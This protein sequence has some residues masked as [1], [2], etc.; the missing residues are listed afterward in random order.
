MSLTDLRMV[1]STIVIA[2]ATV[3]NVGVA[4][5]M[6]VEMHTVGA[7]THDLAV[8]AG[9]QADAAKSQANNTAVLARA[10]VDQVKSL[11]AGVAETHALASAAKIQADTAA[12]ANKIALDATTVDERAWVSVDVGEKAGNFSVTMRNTGKSPAINVSEVTAFAG[13]NRMGPPEVDFSQDS[14]S[15]VLLPKDAPP[16]LLERLKK[17]GF[18]RDRP[19][20]GYVIAPGDTQI[21]SVYQGK[22]TQIFRIGGDRVY[23]QGRVTYNDIFGKFHETLFCYWFAPPSDF[24]MCNDHNK[25]N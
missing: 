15:A 10:A 3:V 22:F 17:E 16:E 11:E 12:A 25:M 4:Y 21:A 9:K 8:A 24:A 6:W 13:G 18:I 14:S 7:D 19:P 23:V 2:V 5:R 1:I 20:S